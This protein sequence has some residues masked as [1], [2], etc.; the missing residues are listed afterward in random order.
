MKRI[1]SVLLAAA[2]LISLLC[3]VALADDERNIT[4]SSDWTV[5][6]IDPGHGG[7]GG[8]AYTWN[9][10]KYVE[11]ELVLKIAYYLKA[12][13]EQYHAPADHAN[14]RLGGNCQNRRK[15]ES[16]SRLSLLLRLRLR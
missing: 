14:L 15:R 3:T 8:G 16:L 10:H 2:M 13:L 1:I 12:E 5:I 6:T 4:P 9:G 11:T 7:N